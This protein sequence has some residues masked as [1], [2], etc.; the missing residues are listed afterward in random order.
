MLAAQALIT[1]L[2]ILVVAE[3]IPKALFHSNSNF[4]LKFFA[5]PLVVVHYLLL[6]PGLLVVGLNN[7]SIRLVG[8]S[9]STN[10]DEE[11]LGATDLDHFVREMSGRMEPE[12]ELEHELQIIKTPWSST[13]Y[14]LG[15][16][17]FL[18]T[19]WWPWIW[20]RPSMKFVNC[21]S[22]RG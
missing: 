19:R 3:F 12:Q 5:V 10:N 14:S 2:V 20:K 11:Q 9:G 6:L 7:F 15:T 13:R 17:S 22:Q 21:S 18:A 1:T 16:A 4:W 8:R